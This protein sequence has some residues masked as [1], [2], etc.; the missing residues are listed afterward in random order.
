M[1]FPTDWTVAASHIE[2]EED[3]GL[4][5]LRNLGNTCFLNSTLQ[6]LSCVPAFRRYF[7]EVA[8]S[9][10]T[11]LT[12]RG[13]MPAALTDCFL[14]L[15]ASRARVSDPRS[16]LRCLSRA[17]PLFAGYQQ[18]DAHEALRFILNMAHDA[19]AVQI[20]HSYV[21][22]ATS[23]AVQ[24]VRGQLGAP[25]AAAPAAAEPEAAALGAPRQLRLP[26]PQGGAHPLSDRSWLVDGPYTP[27]PSRSCSV[28]SDLFQGVL[29]SRVTCSR[30]GHESVTFETCFDLSLSIPGDRH[31]NSAAVRRQEHAADAS[32]GP[33]AAQSWGGQP[34][35]HLRAPG[36]SV[37]ASLPNHMHSLQM[38]VPTSPA[39]AVAHGS[40]AG[41]GYGVQG[42]PTS[43]AAPGAAA[44]TFESHSPPAA[45]SHSHI[46]TAKL[47]LD[48][49]AAGPGIA[50]GAL[51]GKQA[52]LQ[53]WRAEAATLQLSSSAVVA[54]D[55]DTRPLTYAQLQEG[56]AEG[57]H[58]GPGGGVQPSSVLHAAGSGGD[59]RVAP[60]GASV[61]QGGRTPAAPNTEGSEPE[62][63]EK[64]WWQSM[65]CGGGWLG[66]GAVG[67]HD[68]LQAFCDEETL[69]GDNAYMCSQCKRKVT[70]TRRVALA[71]APEVLVVHLKRFRH[72]GSWGSKVSTPVHF[73]LRNLNLDPYIWSD[74]VPAAR[75]ALAAH[76]SGAGV[77]APGEGDSRHPLPSNPAPFPC[78]HP[79][80]PQV[81]EAPLSDATAHELVGDAFTAAALKAA[82][83][84]G[85]AAAAA[86]VGPG[87]TGDSTSDAHSGS[88]RNTYSLA[89][90]VR[91]MGG[92]G[93]GHYVA[94]G[95]N[96][97][98]GGNGLLQGTTDGRWYTFN[99]SGV[100]HSDVDQVAGTEAYIMFYVRNQRCRSPPVQAGDFPAS[101]ALPRPL[102]A[103]PPLKVLRKAPLRVQGLDAAAGS[104]RCA[105]V[106]LPFA[107][108]AAAC[109]VALGPTVLVSRWWWLRL[110]TCSRP[111][112]VTCADIATDHGALKPGLSSSWSREQ[113]RAHAVVA[114]PLPVYE[115]LVRQFGAAGPPL[116]NLQPC[117]SSAREAQV[118][119]ERRTREAQAVARVDSTRAGE[120]GGVP[121]EG[122]HADST[123]YLIS[124]RWLRSWRAF[125]DNKGPLDG[126]GRGVLPPGPV[127]NACLMRRDGTP[128]GNLRP[129]TH[130]RGI[131][132]SVWGMFIS[133]YGGGPCIRRATIDMYDETPVPP[134]PAAIHAL[135]PH[136]CAF[137]GL[138]PGVG[139]FIPPP[140]QQPPPPLEQEGSGGS[141]SP[142]L[143]RGP[144]T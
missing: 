14:G 88:L 90:V 123:W 110:Q 139:W 6:A 91:H 121:Q 48:G 95:R 124:S 103:M 42:G 55:G 12:E 122:G 134:P 77:T 114:L 71:R 82:A 7:C 30:C 86:V 4:I 38:D 117:P 137:L 49:A 64:S 51:P 20:P 19:L 23:P 93:G 1:V 13:S 53:Q 80:V 99:D 81:S 143:A 138:A 141:P 62:A 9:S 41:G 3:A 61:L 113:Q 15:W 54:A 75:A 74:A 129:R 32:E 79:S 8:F 105:L 84:A 26:A 21:T 83:A 144:A 63:Q 140:G 135:A 73:P 47:P 33:P 128:Q 92:L 29:A 46:I 87:S 130:Y 70:A 98:D 65:L 109:G 28:V 132:A 34:G 76:G 43:P 24:F 67:L 57:V 101:P 5:G 89:S 52:S 27:P 107:T 11:A 97:G 131:N 125:I 78:P 22:L 66:G 2:Y 115:W 35:V 127:D 39:A 120:G 108:H 133:M 58:M 94:L 126:T 104:T 31:P 68:C 17:N 25:V 56:G 96:D 59:N 16:V 136:S 100:S 102:A 36:S 69:S 112:P 37:Q 111:G 119:A 60:S 18:Q 72:S 10:M 40:A 116:W 85:R 44:F 106:P 50:S 45:A 118:L 142:G